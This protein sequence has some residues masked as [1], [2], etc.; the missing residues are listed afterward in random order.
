MLN[1]LKFRKALDS[2]YFRDLGNHSE[3]NLIMKKK[4]IFKAI[5]ISI[6]FVFVLIV[7]T[8]LRV[9]D[10][11]EDYH[12]FHKVRGDNKPDYLVMNKDLAKKYFKDNGLKSDNQSDLFLKVKTDGTFRIFV[13]GASTVVGFP[14]YRGGSFP[15]MLKH[16]LSFTFP[17]RNIEVINTGMTAVN[18]YTLL[19]LTDEIIKQ[20]PDLVIIYAGHNE[21]Y[22]A[23]GVGSTI[24]YGSHPL[25]IKSYLRL[26]KLRLFQFF[27]N[28]YY[29]FTNT[30]FQKPSERTTT[31]MEVLAK[32]QSIP[33]NSELYLE[34]IN[35]FKNN[36]NRILSKYKKHEIPVILSTLVSN[37]KDI[38]PFISKDIPD[39]NEFDQALEEE[40]PLANRIAMS[41]AN[42]AFKL[43]RFYLKNNVDTAKKY[44][45]L[46]KELDL[47]RFRAPEK[48]N[49]LIVDLSREYNT[50]LVDMKSVFE[51]NSDNGIIGNELMTEHVHPTIEGQFLM[52]D[53]F[54][55]K[56]KELDL[57]INWN[58][59][60]P[61]EEAIRDIPVSLIDSIQ[62]M[63]VISELKSSWPYNINGPISN[64]VTI[65]NNNSTAYQEL[66]IAYDVKK[67]IMS[68]EQAMSTAYNMYKSNKAYEKALDIAQSL[69][70]EFSEQG[71]VYQMAGDMCM[72]LGDYEKAA[73]YFTRSNYFD[74]SKESVENLAIAYLKTGKINQ[75]KSTLAKAKE[76]GLNVTGLDEL[77]E[78]TR[79]INEE[80]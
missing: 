21:Y 60:I 28:S 79:Q 24:S 56:I 36:L 19:D 59:Y 58:N 46:A 74:Q 8:I 61:Y 35:Q 22:G 52:A 49:E 78:Y 48:I 29:K 10:Y 3:W 50:S 15:R 66:Q 38:K 43:G 64:M 51:A 54:Y 62:G 12:L 45:F 25:V 73:F 9:A 55:E 42:A 37:E 23:L 4:S 27:E 32:E 80:E 1:C 20:K 30:S 14:F 17:D 68:W 11:G 41:N 7:E 26:K 65:A 75:A 18:S 6:P 67:K 47:L 5:A 39:E 2:L 31:L 63:L 16:R 72:K 77:I 53:A 33:Y 76:N 34:G 70:F 13:Q 69:I 57:L 40:N 44:L 71:T